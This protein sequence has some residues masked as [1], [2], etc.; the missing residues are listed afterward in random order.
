[1]SLAF[2]FAVIVLSIFFSVLAFVG[3]YVS[4]RV[5]LQ[6]LKARAELGAI[7]AQLQARQQALNAAQAKLVEQQKTLAMDRAALKPESTA[8]PSL[9][10]VPEEVGQ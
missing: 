7:P 2:Q 6:V 4:A 9:K 1:M 5:F 3:L 8:T 10:V